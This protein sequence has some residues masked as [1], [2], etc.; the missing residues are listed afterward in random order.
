MFN[1]FKRPAPAPLWSFLARYTAGNVAQHLER[2][3]QISESSDEFLRQLILGC[4]YAC[5]GDFL[6]GAGTVAREN[7]GRVNADVIAFEALSFC[8]YAIRENHLPALEDPLDDAEPEALVDAYRDVI[9]V[10]RRQ[11]EKMTDWQVADL[12]N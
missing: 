1:L 5:V 12:W 4:T 10:L 8:I 7:L 6:R 11:V 2:E 3:S 9:F